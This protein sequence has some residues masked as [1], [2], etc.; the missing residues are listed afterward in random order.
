[1]NCLC[2]WETHCGL[3]DKKC[4]HCPC[5]RCLQT[6]VSKFSNRKS[7]TS[8]LFRIF[9]FLLYM[10]PPK[11][12]TF[13]LT[14]KLLTYFSSLSLSNPEFPEWDS[15]ENARERTRMRQQQKRNWT[16]WEYKHSLQPTY[17]HVPT[18]AIFLS[19]GENKRQK[20][21]SFRWNGINNRNDKASDVKK[22]SNLFLPFLTHKKRRKK[23]K[24]KGGKEKEREEGEREGEGEGERKGREGNRKE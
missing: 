2:T 19:P 22:E 17:L 14:P 20:S 18:Y 6:A 13:W 21:T 7:L 3:E 24:S 10:P 1:M 8:I 23:K 4:Q 9:V 16:G 5:N 12:L 11:P 15:G